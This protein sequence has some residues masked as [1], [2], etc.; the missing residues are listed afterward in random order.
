MGMEKR[1]IKACKKLCIPVDCSSVCEFVQHIR[2]L[3]LPTDEDN[4]KVMQAVK[5]AHI[6]GGIFILQ[7]VF[8]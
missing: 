3:H 2:L 6:K 7:I 1:F 4:Q 5:I 8:L